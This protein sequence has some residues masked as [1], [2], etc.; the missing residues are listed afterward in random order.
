MKAPQATVV[1]PKV[2]Q[3]TIVE[4]ITKS[5]QSDAVLEAPP[6][7]LRVYTNEEIQKEIEEKEL[8][9]P[10]ILRTFKSIRATTNTNAKTIIDEVAK[11]LLLADA[12]LF[13]LFI[14]DRTG[15]FLV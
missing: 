4:P 8:S 1:E 6:V 14:I 13:H 12:R 11:K 15:N 9:N 7:I 3:A 10:A 2:P 5:V